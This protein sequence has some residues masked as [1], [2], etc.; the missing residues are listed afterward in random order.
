MTQTAPNRESSRPIRVCMVSF[1]Y[2]PNYSGSAIQAGNLSRYLKR[3][4]VQPF[5]VSARLDSRVAHEEID[6]IPVYRIPVLQSGNLQIPFFWLGLAWFL[7][8][9]R[10]DYDIV[11]AHGTLQHGTASIMARLLGKGSI[12]K[13]AMHRSDIAFR[14]QG[15]I[16]GRI[17]RFYVRRFH[18]YIATSRQIHL[19]FEEEGMESERIVR[20]PNGVDTEK[21]RP[22]EDRDEK[23]ALKAALGLPPVPLA[24]FT[25][26]VIARKNVDFV[27]RVF[28]EIRKAGIP[29]HL[30][31]V[32]PG[33]GRSGKP[34]GPY[35]DSLQVMIR[36]AG[37]EADV[38][39]TGRRPD[40]QDYVRAS[41]LFLFAPRKEGMPNVLLEAMAGGVPCVVSRISG[42]EDVIESGVNGYVYDLDEEDR[43]RQ[44]AADLMQDGELRARIG[45]KATRDIRNR[46]SLDAVADRYVALYNSLLNTPPA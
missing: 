16:W 19:E 22:A 45:E 25:G 10:R 43:F 1:Y 17:N 13:V 7:W 21:F 34:E 11:H 24:L 42:I 23:V 9:K 8:R 40:V 2:D 18:R 41:D 44:A 37:A 20:I 14:R 6:G 15:K 39:F 46:Y 32:G 3:R 27:I 28:L 4:G 29:G 31:V 30:V 38:T 5:V 12:L 33:E 36:E 26:I 35:F